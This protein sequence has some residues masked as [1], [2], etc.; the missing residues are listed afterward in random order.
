MEPIHIHV[1]VHLPNEPVQEIEEALDDIFEL[2]HKMDLK[3]GQVRKEVHAMTPELEAAVREAQETG[4]AVDSAVILLDKLGQQ[5]R[6]NADNPTALRAL[7]NDLDN[8][9]TRLA[10]AIVANTPADPNAGNP[11]VVSG[12]VPGQGTS[13]PGSNA[14]VEG[15]QQPNQPAQPMGGAAS[16]TESGAASSTTGEGAPTE[17][18]PSGGGTGEQPAGPGPEG[19]GRRR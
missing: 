14:P 1:H 8:A 16:S 5:I 17:T 12:A 18:R 7:A 2:L 6:D 15:G 9:Q 4:D 13:N 19:T 11:T 10:Q 3:L